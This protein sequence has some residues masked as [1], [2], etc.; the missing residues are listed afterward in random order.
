MLGF[1]NGCGKGL[2]GIVTESVSGKYL[3]CF[4]ANFV[5]FAHLM[6]GA[7]GVFG[8]TGDGISKSLDRAVHRQTLK[9][10]LTARQAQAEYLS[11]AR[12]TVQPDPKIAE[13]FSRRRVM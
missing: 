7:F 9:H 5:P 8:Y 3:P 2:T 13:A 11:Q 6:Q 10:I 12:S 1:A 4:I